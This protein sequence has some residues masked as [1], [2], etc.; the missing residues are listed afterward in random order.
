MRRKHSLPRPLRIYLAGRYERRE[1][2]NSYASDLVERGHTVSA[3]WLTRKETKDFDEF[4]SI[5]SVAF[6]QP[7]AARDLSDIRHSDVIVTFSE[8]PGGEQK[9]RGG[10]HVELGVALALQKPVVMVGD[11][12]HIF[13]TLP[14]VARF[15]AWDSDLFD[16]LDTL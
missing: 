11:G 15:P 8:R 6:Y 7:V 5:R 3:S 13:H 14:E 2:L 12:E 9:S 10:R 1:E 16:Y 4:D